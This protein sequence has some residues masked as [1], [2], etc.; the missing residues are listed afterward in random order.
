MAVVSTRI[1]DRANED[2]GASAPR[3]ISVLERLDLTGRAEPE[4]VQAAVLLVA[5]GNRSMFDDAV[6]HARD[7]WRDLLDR[8]G[9]ADDAWRDRLDYE[10]GRD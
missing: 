6:E 5:R 7:D 2:F 9:L 3:V 1:I 8:A 4:R 10:L